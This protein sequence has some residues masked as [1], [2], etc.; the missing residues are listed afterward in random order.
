[1]ITVKCFLHS[2]FLSK[3]TNKFFCTFTPKNKPNFSAL[4]QPSPLWVILHRGDLRVAPT[5]NRVEWRGYGAYRAIGLAT[6]A[7][8]VRRG[9]SQEENRGFSSWVE[10]FAPLSV[11]TDRKWNK[12]TLRVLCYFCPFRQKHGDRK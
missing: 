10:L 2:P 4:R 6:R 8:R 12:N 7:A 11:D 9:E 1:M 3:R 5:E